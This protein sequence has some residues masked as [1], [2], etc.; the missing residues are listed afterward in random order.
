[1]SDDPEQI[2]EQ[3]RQAARL[4][5]EARRAGTRVLGN[6]AVAWHSQGAERY[7]Q[8][9]SD[10]RTEFRQRADD[11]EELCRDLFSHARHVEEHERVIGEVV[12]TV[13]KVV[14]PLGLFS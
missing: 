2:R 5:A 3:A 7:R 14:D 4:A 13:K 1:M 9:L 12:G 10:R 8:K 11:L 6:G